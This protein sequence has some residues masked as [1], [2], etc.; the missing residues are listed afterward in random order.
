MAK[1]SA[2]FESP[3]DRSKIDFHNPPEPTW[4]LVREKLYFYALCEDRII[5]CC[6]DRPADDLPRER[7][8]KDSLH[9][10]KENRKA[11]EEA[12]RKAICQASDCREVVIV[13][14]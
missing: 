9:F 1:R 11:I 6:L 10:F 4:S 3:I 2:P 12:A 14:I 13:S 8:E 5:T 7:R